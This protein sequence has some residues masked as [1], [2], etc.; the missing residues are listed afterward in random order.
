M[1]SISVDCASLLDTRFRL[2]T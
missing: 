1:N 2:G